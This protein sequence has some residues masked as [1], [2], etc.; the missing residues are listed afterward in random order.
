MFL[1]DGIHGTLEATEEGL[2]TEKC[3]GKVDF[4]GEFIDCCVYRISKGGRASRRS[5]K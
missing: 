4:V 5:N 1:V 3:G 2:C